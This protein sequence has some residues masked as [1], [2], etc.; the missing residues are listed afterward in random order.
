VR[1]HIFRAGATI[2]HEGE[3]TLLV[4]MGEFKFIAET[5]QDFQIINEVIIDGCYNFQLDV[6]CVVLDIGMNVGMASIYFASKPEVT[7]VYGYEIFEP[8]FKQALRNFSLNQGIAG[9]IFPVNQGV[10][11]PARKMEL[12]YS[13]EVKGSIGIEG[14]EPEAAEIFQSI[15]T[16]QQIMEVELEDC[17]EVVKRVSRENSDYRLIIKLDCEGSEYEIIERLDQ[18]GLLCAAS[19]YMIE[20]HKRGPGPLLE[21]LRRNGFVSLSLHPTNKIVGMIYA[22]RYK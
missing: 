22:T 12:P 3:T 21:I 6:P 13:Y 8:T 16:Q 2:K 1:T 7:K 4:Q 9:K 5:P 10:G 15:D 14:I 11:F 17:A 20:W 18:Q 19:L